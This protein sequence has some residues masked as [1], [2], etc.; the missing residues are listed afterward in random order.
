V[1][2]DTQHRG[3]AISVANVTM[4]YPTSEGSVK[5]LDDISLD[6]RPGEFVS[7]LGPSGCGK[8]TLLMLVA[9][10]RDATGGKISVNDR[11]VRGPETEVGVV[12]QR[13]VL[14][15]WRTNLDNVLLQI[16]FRKLKPD[17]YRQKALDLFHQVGLDGF[18]TKHPYELSGGMRQRVSICRALVHDPPVLLMDE[19]FGALDALTREQMMVDLEEIW[20]T[21][22]KTVLFITH[23]IPEAVFLSDKVLVMT[24]RPGRIFKVAEIDLPRPRSLE[25]TTGVEFNRYVSEI[26]QAFQEMGVIHDVR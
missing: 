4:I 9:G 3:G 5:A 6:I 16:E 1:T 21:S 17:Q 18:E 15:D 22:S 13:D 11:L 26:R 23:S 7:V 20:S 24:P 12:F 2:V 25:A 19:P 8:S 14:L 10:L